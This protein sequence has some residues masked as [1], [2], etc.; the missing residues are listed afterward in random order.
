MTRGRFITLEGGEGVGKST[1]AA[2][3][4]SYLAS[5]GK[6]VVRTRE[7][8]GSPRAERIRALLL[9]T[10]DEPMPTSCEVLLMFAARATHVENVIR[11]ALARGDWV[12]CDRFV[13]AS[14]AYQVAGRG[15][16]HALIEQ[17][18]RFV[19]QD[20]QP[21]LTLLFDAD[22]AVGA[23]RAALRNGQDG[24]DRFEQERADFFT[25]VRQGY[26]DRAHSAP[27]RMVVLDAAQSREAVSQAIADI[28]ERRLFADE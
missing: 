17:L 21:D 16:P 13:D 25:R 10:S 26:L 22:P 23:A 4:E 1:Q 28:V 24:P 9:A 14:Y 15:A 19:L 18:E 7:P 5:R 8:G 12:V 11:P 20:L 3:L 27:E 2:A 6:T